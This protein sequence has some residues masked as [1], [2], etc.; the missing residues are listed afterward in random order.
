MCSA[1]DSPSLSKAVRTCRMASAPLPQFQNFSVP[2]TR[3]LNSL[4]NNSTHLVMTGNPLQRVQGHGASEAPTITVGLP[5]GAPV[6]RFRTFPR[7]GKRVDRD[8]ATR[9]GLGEADRP[10]VQTH[11]RK[12]GGASDQRRLGRERPESPA[13]RGR[14]PAAGGTRPLRTQF[15]NS[16]E[17]EL[18]A[19]S[20]PPTDLGRPTCEATE[21]AQL[22]AA[23]PHVGPII[24][25]ICFFE[26][27]SDQRQHVR[28]DS[29]PTSPRCSSTEYEP[30]Q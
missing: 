24:H 6:K 13:N 23:V 25:P 8:S 4:V 30:S 15:Y 5:L 14:D 18:W 3:K 11:R 1:K 27:E 21:T 7:C 16:G 20:F 17:R 26:H 22:D 12:I 9:N 10:V 29:D 28:R 2:L 19:F